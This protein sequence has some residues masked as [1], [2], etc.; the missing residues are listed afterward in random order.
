M[1]ELIFLAVIAAFVVHKLIQTLGKEDGDTQ[2]YAKIKPAIDSFKNKMAQAKDAEFEIISKAE[3]SLSDDVKQVFEEIRKQDERFNAKIFIDGAKMAFE[4]IVG[5]FNNNDKNTLKN[6]LNENLYKNFVAEIDRRISSGLT[7][8]V[9]IVG[10]KNVKILDASI[11]NKIISIRI[12]IESDQIKVIKDQE[13]NIVA[14]NLKEI[15]QLCD[16][17][18]FSK[19]IKSKNSWKLIKTETK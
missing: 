5:A 16:I 19:A 9:T 13:R 2:A 10:I 7:H 3:A 11:E 15:L 18:T 14:G 8:N 1:L 12:A 4:M 17:W 6:L